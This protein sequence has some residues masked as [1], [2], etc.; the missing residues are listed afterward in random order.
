MIDYAKTK[1]G[2]TNG[3]EFTLS[4]LPFVGY[5][6]I[7]DGQP[8]QGEDATNLDVKIDV[9]GTLS[10][11]VLTS[12]LFY[13]RIITETASL[14]YKFDKD[15][16]IAPNETCNSRL[17]NDRILKLY[18][19]A[20]YLYSQL[21]LA[22]N[23]IPN[24]YNKA[25]G[26][27]KTTKMLGWSTESASSGAAFA[28]F[29]SAGYAQIDDAIAFAAAK[30]Y[31]DSNVYFGITPTAFISMSADKDLTALSVVNIN[32]TISKNNDLMFTQL[33]SFSIAGNYAYLCDSTQNTIYK[34]DV[35]GYISGDSSILNRRIYVDSIGGFG[36]A[37]A[38][39]KFDKPDLVYANDSINR[40]FVHDRNNRCIK[41]YD[42]NLSFVRI[43]TFT[44]GSNS[45]AK[46]MAYNPVNQMMY[47]I[48][49]NA[50]TNEHVLQI[51]DSDL[52]LI[53]QYN[54][55]DALAS[56]EIYKGIVFSKNDSNIFYIFTNQGVYKKFVNKPDKTIG[57]WLI[58]KSGINASH[59]WNL[60]RSK[61]N[62]ASWSWNEGATSV[63]DALTIVG[64]SSFF[65]SDIDDREQIFLF[66]GANS[67][68][69][70][71]VLHYIE[72]NV[73]NSVMGA[74]TLNAYDV[75]Y[76]RVGDDEFVN[77]MVIN[78]EL[79]KAAF[80]TISIIRLITGR[81]A[82]EYDYL[83]N[84][85]YKNIIPLTDAESASVN[86][87]NLQNIYVHENEI[88]NSSSA[89]NRCFKEIYNL[90]HTALQ[91]VRTKINNAVSSLSG[92]QTIVLN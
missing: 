28:P 36:N 77:A 44:A 43:R 32:S 21:F 14:P 30:T 42:T 12:K 78:K 8:Y 6:H 79:Y 61:Y 3:N 69:F 19:N 56:N 15:I 35:S 29:A 34:Y 53:E 72:R 81:Y 62:L 18:N 67:K 40:L 38:Q 7:I 83:N 10:S 25:A 68:S 47:I 90:Q 85:I 9:Q 84:L 31:D 11:N 73:Y 23:D 60:E 52:Q 91:I 57:K 39:T 88:M 48:I 65:I 58:Y 17:F 92:T 89:L 20:I 24:G 41:V 33:T 22:S 64:M 63:R 51:C 27:S 71:R 80:N 66:V 1:I 59:I 16:F 4:S 13:D 70:N 50:A 46:A 76:A 55:P 37:L 82:A 87:T 49:Q 86:S 54:L 26:V 75:A 45:V 2:F 5:Y 74:T